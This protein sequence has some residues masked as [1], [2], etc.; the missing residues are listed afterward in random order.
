[1]EKRIWRNIIIELLKKETNAVGNGTYLLK[2]SNAA[3]N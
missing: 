2:V 3:T 1:M